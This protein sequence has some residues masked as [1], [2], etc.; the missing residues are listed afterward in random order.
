LLAKSDKPLLVVTTNYDNLIEKALRRRGLPFDL[1]IHT[2]NAEDGDVLLWWEHGQPGPRREIP[3]KIMPKLEERTV[4]YKM[5]GTVNCDDA[6]LDQFVITEDDYTEFLGRMI[7]GT[8]LPPIIAQRFCERH[9]LFLGYGLRDWNF[10]VLLRY[11]DALRH[12]RSSRKPNG[13]SPPNNA[14][15]VRHAWHRQRAKSWA[16][17]R[18]PSPFETLFWQRAEVNLYNWELEDFCSQLEK[19]LNK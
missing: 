14:E 3:K 10:R 11:V 8:V 19:E 18:E 9:F 6:S 13:A 5:H 1:I 4:I 12:G 17:L 15:Q 7:R 16:I 2:A